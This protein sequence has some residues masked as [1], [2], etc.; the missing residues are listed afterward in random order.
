M[1]SMLPLFNDVEG[2]LAASARQG[3]AGPLAIATRDH[4]LI[5]RW[6]A[7]HGAEPATGEATASGPATI[8]VRDGGVG[9]R[10]NFPGAGHFRPITWDEWFEHFDRHHLTFVYEEEVA[11]RAYALWEARGGDHGQDRHDWFEA[12]R[13]MGGSQERPMGR[14]RLTSAEI[15]L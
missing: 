11:D 1:N 14:Y 9:I 15:G 12:E 2:L 4:D 6:G 13:Q 3:G 8:H 10:L 5:R 7:R